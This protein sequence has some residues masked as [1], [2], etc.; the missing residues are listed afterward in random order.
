MDYAYNY[1][2]RA[3]ALYH[4]GE[5]VL[6]R[7]GSPRLSWSSLRRRPRPAQPA[8]AASAG[9]RAEHHERGRQRSALVRAGQPL[10]PFAPVGAR[11]SRPEA[12]VRAATARALSLKR[13]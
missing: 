13:H 7:G 11:R 2:G 5:E 12:T 4:D 3:A 10:D 8:T 9:K 1:Q 6:W